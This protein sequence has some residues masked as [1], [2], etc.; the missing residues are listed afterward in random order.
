LDKWNKRQLKSLEIAGNKYVREKFN[1][2]GVT[3]QSGI[4]EYSSDSVQKYKSELS[5]IIKC[6]LNNTLITD[7]NIKDSSNKN[8]ITNP[9]TSEVKQG[10]MVKDVSE[11]NF[12]DIPV[13]K[14]PAEEKPKEP[15]F[16][17]ATKFNFAE[18]VNIKVISSSIESKSKRNNQK[19]Q[20]VDFDFNF[21]NFNEVNFS[22][23]NN[24]PN[25]PPTNKN[26]TNFDQE[27][28]SSSSSNKN[29]KF[30][31]DED[32]NEF[33]KQKIS[34]EEINKKFAN[35]KAISSEDYA[36]LE[37]DPNTNSSFKNKLNN[38]KYSQAISSSDLYG[39][40]NE[41]GIIYFIK[42]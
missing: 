13:S 17:Q 25:D 30:D 22:S 1:E 26:Q 34:K 38:M 6:L 7:T 31:Q 39:E 4:Y 12:D 20:K 3:K 40:P 27:F 24:V 18:N 5:E 41:E 14:P 29:N 42:F 35:K 10:S 36:N 19:I 28:G 32:S 11:V 9:N 37:E 21:D 8:V 15:E 16:K 23:F 2:Y 33:K